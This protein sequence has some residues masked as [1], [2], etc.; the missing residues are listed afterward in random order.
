VAYSRYM[1]IFPNDRQ[2][3][4]EIIVSSTPRGTLRLASRPGR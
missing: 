3:L 4:Q 1:P 2:T